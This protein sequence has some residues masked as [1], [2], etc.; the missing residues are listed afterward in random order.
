MATDGVPGNAERDRGKNIWSE[1]KWKLSKI[2]KAKKNIDKLKG[3]KQSE[4]NLQLSTCYLGTI[5]Y[6]THNT[7]TEQ[8]KITP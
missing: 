2:M 4:A 8:K 6:L 7:L 5:T 3:H 1:K